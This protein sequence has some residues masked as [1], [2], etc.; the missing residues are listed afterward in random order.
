[1]LEKEKQK[2]E[3][4]RKWIRPKKPIKIV[5]LR[6][7]SKNEKNEKT[8]FSSKNCLTLFVSGREKNTH[9]R[10]HYLFWPNIFRA[11]TVK[12]KKHN[13]DSG[14]SG[15][16]PKPKKKLTPFFFRKRCFFGMG[17]KVVFTNCVFEKLCS[18]ENTNFIVRS[19]KPSSCSKKDAC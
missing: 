5:F 11:K 19:A 4:E 16:C 3:N 10:A 8:G 9:F 15:N 1:M 18:S 6:W 2:K 17:E 7:S 12:T 13:K 14:F